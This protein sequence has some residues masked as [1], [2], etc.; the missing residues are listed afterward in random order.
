MIDSF[1]FFNKQIS[2]IVGKD[3]NTLF[4]RHDIQIENGRLHI[5]DSE[6]YNCT[7]T[8]NINEWSLGDQIWDELVN[9]SSLDAA[10]LTSYV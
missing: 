7:S 9:V 3:V 5:G 10:F 1:I 4:G 6:G 8:D 2:Q